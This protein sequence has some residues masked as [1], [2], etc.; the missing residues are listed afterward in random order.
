MLRAIGLA[1]A[2]TTLAALAAPSV[3]DETAEAF[4]ALLARQPSRP[5][6]ALSGGGISP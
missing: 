4:A 5:P 6:G 3:A 1:I 2:L